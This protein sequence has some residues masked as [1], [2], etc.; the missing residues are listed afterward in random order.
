M[1][2]LYNSM[3]KQKEEFKPI[4]KTVGIYV[5]GPTVY[6]YNHIGHA[7]IF[8]TFDYIVRYLRDIG[9]K[10][11]YVR[12]ITDVDDKIIN[13][14]NEANVNIDVITRRYIDGL[15]QD[16]SWLDLDKPTHQPR[17]TEYIPEI[18][19]MI[20]TLEHKGFAY[21]KPDGV[22]FKLSKAKKL[23]QL[24]N[25][26]EFMDEDDFVLWKFTKTL[27]EPSW[28]TKWGNGRPGWHIECSAMATTLLGNTIDIHGGGID[29]VFPHHD[30]EILQ[31]EAATGEKYVN[32]WMHVGHVTVDGMKMGKSLGNAKSTTDVFTWY[33]P[34]VLKFFMIS[35][36]YG[37]PVDYSDHNMLEA[38]K[39]LT[40]FYTTLRKVYKAKEYQKYDM[41]KDVT[42]EI[43]TEWMDY[44]NELHKALEDDFN[45]PMVISIFFNILKQINISLDGGNIIRAE[46]LSTNI[47]AF[48][49]LF[50]LFKTNFSVFLQSTDQIDWNEVEKQIADRKY[51]KDG[52]AYEQADHI[53]KYLETL[54]II[55]EDHKDGSTTWRRK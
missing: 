50:G 16:Y 33:H 17:V 20:E 40:K 15:D 18:I 32:T 25:R 23:G 11:N 13:K 37:S 24:S 45:T 8:I 47:F 9:H 52:K 41:Y 14:A 4:N 53:R 22:Y 54:D 38:R 30:N 3:T 2:K 44:R 35:S 55:L 34:E 48:G 39:S 31:S 36:H 7:R 42:E 26:T 5:C 46:W 19:K 1:L 29:L 10:V 49:K 51:Y 21:V 6:D 27:N 28:Y 43:K 12:N